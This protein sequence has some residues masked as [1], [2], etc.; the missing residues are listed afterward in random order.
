MGMLFGGGMVIK[1]RTG[2]FAFEKVHIIVI[3]TFISHDH[4]MPH[5]RR[6]YEAT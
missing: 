6:I 3:Q 4:M 1:H 2:K 5:G